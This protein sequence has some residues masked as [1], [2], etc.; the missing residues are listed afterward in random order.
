MRR[1]APKY[2]RTMTATAIEADG[3]DYGEIAAELGVSRQRVQQ[4]ERAAL[5]KARRWV[6]ENLPGIDLT[7]LLPGLEH[8]RH[9]ESQGL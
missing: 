5:L 9:D 7:D 8:G 2:H 4:I 6:E 1:P 3:A